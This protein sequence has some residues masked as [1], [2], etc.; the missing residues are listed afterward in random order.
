MKKFIIFYSSFLFFSS[1]ARV[2][3]Q[4]LSKVFLTT[5]EGMTQTLQTKERLKPFHSKDFLMHQPYQKV[6][7]LLKSPTEKKVIFTYHSNGKIYQKLECENNQA[8]GSYQE[9]TPDGE[10]S[11][12]AHLKGGQAAVDQQAQSTWIF[13]GP[14]YAYNKKGLLAATFIY[15]NG[16][17]EGKTQF[18]YPSGALKEERSY[19]SGKLEGAVTTYTEKGEVASECNYSNSQLNGSSILYWSPG[20]LAAKELYEEGKLIEGYYFDE[21][22]STKAKVQNGM[23][24]KVRWKENGFDLIEIEGGEPSGLVESFTKA[25]HLINSYSIQ[26]G[27]KDGKET[28]FDEKTLNPI[29]EVTWKQG[30]IQGKIT[31][32]YPDGQLES[33]RE[34]LNNQKHG[35]YCARYKNGDF[36]LI[37]EYQL[38]KLVKGKYYKKGEGLPVTKIENGSGEATFFNE[39]G[40]LT[41]QVL[42][43]GGKPLE[44]I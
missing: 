21:L 28:V 35:V 29:L 17:L 12:D 20:V 43:E 32:W 34:V 14:C 24:Q 15:L 8:F 4:P 38:G 16:F 11:I 39:D 30:E 10:L 7:C 25:G 37:E 6:I 40:Q 33:E 5:K 2:T 9:W 41:Q 26:N 42:Y 44:Q 1:C 19:Y 31:T 36:S 27:L 23:G 18:Y 22:Q 3:D 13:D